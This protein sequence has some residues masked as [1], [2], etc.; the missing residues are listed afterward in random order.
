MLAAVAGLPRRRSPAAI[1]G[2]IGLLSRA[3][4]RARSRP[5]G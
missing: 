5:A 4:A 3:G 1:A 2:V